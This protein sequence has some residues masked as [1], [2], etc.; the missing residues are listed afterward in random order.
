MIQLSPGCWDLEALGFS[1]IGPSID[2]RCG[3]SGGPGRVYLRHQEAMSLRRRLILPIL[4]LSL[5][6]CTGLARERWI[7]LDSPNFETVSNASEKKSRTLIRELEKFRHVFSELFH[8]TN[9]RV[10]VTVFIFRNDKSFTS[11]KPVYE[12]KPTSVAGFFQGGRDRNVIALNATANENPLHV[13]FHEYVHLLTSNKPYPW[14]VWVKEGLAE[15]YSTFQVR[16]RRLNL[17]APIPRHAE[18]LRQA[19]MYSVEN[20]FSVGHNSPEYNET[21]KRGCLLCPVLGAGALPHAP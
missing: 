5:V 12:G 10:P 19:R 3:C 4:I 16:G 14:P 9:D 13:I 20:L 21:R 1:P 17:G 15:F 6:P 7:R 2:P 8:L 11:F 18:T